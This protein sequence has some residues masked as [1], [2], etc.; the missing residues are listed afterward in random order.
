MKVIHRQF[1]KKSAL[2]LLASCS[3]A[4]LSS[5][6]FAADKATQ[7]E[8]TRGEY[9]AYAGDCMAC[10]TATPD[11]PYAGG[12]GLA[13][14]LGTIYATNIT[15]DKT[16]GIGNYTLEDFDKAV[17]AGISKNHGALYPAMPFVS[18]A[19]MTDE[20]IA[21]LYAYFMNEVAAI[22]EPNLPTDIEFPLNMRFP[23]YAWNS[24]IADKSAFVPNSEKSDEWNRGAYLVQ[25][26]A[27]CGTCHTPR[28]LALNEQGT[29]EANDLF[30]SGAQLGGWFAPNL[31]NIEMS[32]SELFTLLKEG[33]NETH[34]FAG[35]MADVTSF[36]L[37][38]LTDEDVQS[39]IIY[40]RDIQLPV[41]EFPKIGESY[42]PQT[43]GYTLYQDFCS[44][45][46]GANGEG[47]KSVAPT[48]R[49]R[50]NGE[51]GRSLNVAN[52]LLSGA[53]TAHREDQV[54]YNMPSYQDKLS[55]EQIA[56]I[57]NFIMNNKEW[58]NHNPLISA[59]DVADI[60]ESKPAIRG[61]WVIVGGIIV[62]S[63]LAQLIARRRKK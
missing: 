14:P 63:I 30:L 56:N 43:E 3:F 48:L 39:M 47:V 32:D 24:L 44:T 61:W 21:A 27:H 11:K 42:N 46:H 20:D 29:T 41:A 10:H 25:G 4:L 26:A 22:A 36:S 1:F 6:A 51:I 9:L 18:Y 31:R 58:N 2:A 7:E 5:T 57:V 49:D 34:A 37:R 33:K 50:G 12:H 15:P 52:A 45:C 8:I 55:N 62:I 17:R 59:T 53:E 60:K 13:S 16:H 23:L 54:A 38:H 40:L 28:G 19:K 35:P